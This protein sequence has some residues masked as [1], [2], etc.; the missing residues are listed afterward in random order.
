MNLEEIIYRRRSIRRFKQDP[1]S[2][3]KLKK[4]IDFARV[5]PMATN[6]QS[7]EFIIVKNADIREKLFP[8]VNFASL[9]PPDQRTPEKGREPTAYI[10]V[11][12]N[13]KIKRV[14]VDFNVGAAVENIL[15]GAVSFGIGSCWM[16]NINRNK[17]RELFEIP[18]YYDIN[19][20]ISLGY[21]DEES[22][23]EPYEDSFK[24]WKDDV[25]R[26]HVPKRALE[27]IIFKIY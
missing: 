20:V 25:G 1:I 4:L 16:A 22:V 13:T 17:I 27:E 8:L 14:L 12:V 21:P 26:M 7:L 15:L 6:I 9:L 24:Y 23:M 5:A 19:H 18:E 2:I 11:L 10:I 3:D